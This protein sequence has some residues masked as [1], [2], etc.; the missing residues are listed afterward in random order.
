MDWTLTIDLR[1]NLADVMLEFRLLNSDRQT[2]WPLSSPLSPGDLDILVAAAGTFMDPLAND[3]ERRR[4]R[5]LFNFLSQR[6]FELDPFLAQASVAEGDNLTISTMVTSIPWDLVPLSHTPLGHFVNVGFNVPTPRE[7]TPNRGAGT[8]A[9]C[10]LHLIADPD[11][12]LEYASDEAQDIKALVAQVNGLEYC[13]IMHSTRANLLAAFSEKRIAYLHFT[14]HVTPGEGLRL[15][16]GTVFLLRDI[17]RYFPGDGPKGRQL[18]F[19]NGCDRTPNDGKLQADAFRSASTANAFLRGGARAVVAPRSEVLDAD[20]ARAAA[21]IWAD[22]FA[23]GL[24]GSVIRKFRIAT[25]D[26]DSESAGISYVLYGDP[27]SVI[28]R[29]SAIGDG[30]QRAGRSV[31][32]RSL[33]VVGD[34]RRLA[35]GPIA[36]RHLFASLSRRWALGHIYFDQLGQEYVGGLHALRLALDATPMAKGNVLEFTKA[37]ELVL[38]RAADRHD[39]HGDEDLAFIE[40]LSDVDD[41]EILGALQSLPVGPRTVLDIVPAVREWSKSA[42]TTPPVVFLPSG[43]ANPDWALRALLAVGTERGQGTAL[44]AW[45]FLCLIA[46]T[47]G[48]LGARWREER[49]PLPMGPARWNPGEY[50]SWSGFADDL[51]EAWMRTFHEMDVMKTNVSEAIVVGALLGALEWDALPPDARKLLESHRRTK[52]DWE[53][54]STVTLIAS[55]RW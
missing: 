18:V 33:P 10:F 45:D 21:R 19:V 51:K 5:H 29:Q 53:L 3:I 2:V 36:P 47:D 24:L 54:F 4:Q 41:P 17:V 50:L 48:R 44:D 40:A 26:T 31:D 52:S 35:A 15:S 27:A 42:R 28:V 49:L 8:G 43:N 11:G 14:G 37:G 1:Q 32:L 9:A 7:S 12:D 30:T 38:Q 20:A 13:R 6:S 23:G 34:A 55:K 22:I 25:H 46:K 16:D 39:V